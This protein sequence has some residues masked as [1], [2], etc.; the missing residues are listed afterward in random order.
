M[1]VGLLTSRDTTCGYSVQEL[2][3]IQLADECISQLLRAKEQHDQPPLNSSKSQP[4]A[5]CQLLQ[6]WVISNGV[7]WRYFA[8]PYEGQGWLQLVIPKV[9]REEIL[10]EVHEGVAGGH[11]GQD[12]T[13]SWTIE[14]L[15]YIGSWRLLFMLDGSYAHL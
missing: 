1:M 5:Y 12:K 13:L 3:N 15:I 11:L 6:Q 7:L 4:L 10:R 8:Q 14:I 2:C 9:L